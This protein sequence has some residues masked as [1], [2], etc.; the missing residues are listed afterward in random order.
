MVVVVVVFYI[1]NYVVFK[2]FLFMVVGIIDYELGMWDMCKLNGLWKYMFY[3]VILVMVVVFFMVGVL[4]LNGFFFKE[5][6]FIEIL[7]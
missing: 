5:M 1:I 3:M 2:V 4:L 6:F 7:N